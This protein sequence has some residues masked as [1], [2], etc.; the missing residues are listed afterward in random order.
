[1]S[2]LVGPC[3][4]PIAGGDDEVFF[5]VLP[6]ALYLDTQTGEAVV[7]LGLL[8]VTVFLGRR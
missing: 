3:L 4:V 2:H 1:L 8:A 7:T 5:E 6:M